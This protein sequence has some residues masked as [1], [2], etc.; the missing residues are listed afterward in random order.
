MTNGT[1]GTVRSLDENT[2]SSGHGNS[3]PAQEKTQPKEIPRANSKDARSIPTTHNSTPSKDTVLSSS[4]DSRPTLSS[5]KS[6]PPAD[7]APSSPRN[8]AHEKTIPED[9]VMS[10][11]ES[12][13]PSTTTQEAQAA[14]STT[15][16]QETASPIPG[17]SVFRAPSNSVPAA[18][19]HEEDP[20]TFEPSIDHAKAHQAAIARQTQNKR[21]LSDKELAEQE[22]AQEAVLAEI[23][24][25]PVRVKYPDQSMIETVIT[26][27]SAPRDLYQQVNQTLASADAI[28]NFQLKFVGPKGLLQELPDVANKRLVKGFGFKGRMLVT[29]VWSATASAKVRTGPCLKTEL[30]NVAQDLKVELGNQ[31]KEGE[32]NHKAAMDKKPTGAADG[33]GKKPADL[34]NKMKKFLGLGKK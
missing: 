16:L 4:K 10:N 29:I 28:G 18:A 19:L 12:V 5:Q 30:A 24:T 32:A 3:T 27:D 31:R 14:P 8:V 21:L 22:A 26:A 11:S 7:I 13:G 6:T 17:I 34:E 20:Q 1:A 33:K 23:K 25:V 2:L 15:P 9:T